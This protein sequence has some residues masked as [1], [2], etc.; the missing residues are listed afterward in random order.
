[1]ARVCTHSNSSPQHLVMSCSNCAGI[2]LTVSSDPPRGTTIQPY[3]VPPVVIG[4]SVDLVCTATGDPPISFAWV[5]MGEETTR[6]NSDPTSGSFT[7]TITQVNQYGAY[8]CITTNNLGTD[9]A[10][11]NIIQASKSTSVSNEWNKV[12]NDWLKFVHWIL[13][14]FNYCALL[15]I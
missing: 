7:L 1:M 6:L 15:L 8:I 10:S 5:L 14:L 4:Q 9:A 11:I 13:A 3:P 2:N 12:H